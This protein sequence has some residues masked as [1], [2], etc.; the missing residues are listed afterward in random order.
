M[1]MSELEARG[2]Q[3]HE[4]HRDARQNGGDADA[5]QGDGEPDGKAPAPMEKA[6]LAGYSKDELELLIDFAERGAEF[7]LARVADLSEG[8]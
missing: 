7:A 1:I 4:C 3:D 8:K 2:P 5:H 6:M